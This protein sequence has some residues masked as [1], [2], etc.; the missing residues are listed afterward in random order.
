MHTSAALRNAVHRWADRRAPDRE[1]VAVLHYRR[2]YI[3]PTRVGLAFAAM[4]LVMWLGAANYSNSLVFMLCFLLGAM[5]TVAI[6]HT[7]RTL[8]G[9]RVTIDAA[10]PVFAGE[11]AAFPVRLENPGRRPRYGIG[12]EYGGRVQ[13][14]ADT[15]GGRG[16]RIVVRLPTSRRGV[17]ELDRVAVFSQF[18]TG[19]FRAWT[20]VRPQASVLVYPAP[21]SDA[22]PRPPTHGHIAHGTRQ[23]GSEDDFRG[24]RR[25]QPGDPPRHVAWR[26]LARG[27][28]LQ[29][30]QFQGGGGNRYQFDWADTEG[31]DTE[32]RLAR[33]CRW[34]LDADRSGHSYGL[35]LPGADIPPGRGNAH[36]DRCLQALARY[37]P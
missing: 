1:T 21:E 8:A 35:N 4:L 6:V 29:T 2:I 33:L 28:E 5:A 17:A 19:L 25:Y 34:I 31:L 14:F 32:S 13:G 30:K 15:G 37:S 26:T 3:L 7:F 11:A 16:S 10:H 9:L 18:P 20:W 24:L 27:A 36:R 23:G 22:V 12:V